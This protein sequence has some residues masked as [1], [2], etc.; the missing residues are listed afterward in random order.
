[1]LRNE[2]ETDPCATLRR[3]RQPVS[4]PQRARF[5]PERECSQRI[6]EDMLSELGRAGEEQE[7]EHE[8][9]SAQTEE[10]E[11]RPGLT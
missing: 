2:R 1:M 7:D 3:E 9:V 8:M 11:T 6:L 10:A 4:I 5:N